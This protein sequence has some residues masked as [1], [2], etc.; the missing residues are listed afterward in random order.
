MFSE[1]YC[2]ICH[3]KFVEIE[4]SNSNLLNVECEICGNFK[5]SKSLDEKL[6]KSQLPEHY[7]ISQAIRKLNDNNKIPE[8]NK[9]NLDELKNSSIPYLGTED[10]TKR[11]L[12]YFFKKSKHM[13]DFIAFRSHLD[14][15]VIG[16]TNSDEADFIIK[17]CVEEKLLENAEDEYDLYVLTVKGRKHFE[18]KVV[19]NTSEKVFIAMWFNADLNDSYNNGIKKILIKLGFSPLRIDEKEHNNK[20]DD[21]ILKEIENSFFVIADLTGQRGG[22]YLEAGYA[23]GKGKKVIWSVK[24][25]DLKNIHFDIRQYNFI[26]WKDVNDLAN[27][28]EKRIKETI[29]IL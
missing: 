22:V 8:V 18:S 5:I 2:P 20:I 10:G 25:G 17:H 1:I 27:K 12:E 23:L 9:N 26:V 21:E 19:N 15:P 29:L 4:E 3:G 6:G 13:G 16:A 7:L 14:Y 28:L 24:D 11:A